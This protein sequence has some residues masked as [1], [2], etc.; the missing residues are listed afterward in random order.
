MLEKNKKKTP[1]KKKTQKQNETKI[2][3]LIESD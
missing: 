2:R 3:S 1:K